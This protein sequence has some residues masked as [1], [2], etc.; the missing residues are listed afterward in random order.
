[1]DMASKRGNG[2]GSIRHNVERNRWEGRISMS[3]AR[4]MVTA[5]T[6]RELTHRMRI[7]QRRRARSAVCPRRF[8]RSADT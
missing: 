2:K 6:R 7:A 4:R 5:R 8:S 3:D 1:M